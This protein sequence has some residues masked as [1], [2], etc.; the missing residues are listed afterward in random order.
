MSFCEWRNQ[1]IT[2]SCSLKDIHSFAQ[3]PVLIHISII[4]LPLTEENDN[5]VMNIFF[6]ISANS[7]GH[8]DKYTNCKYL[9]KMLSC[10]HELLKK[11]CKATCLCEGKIH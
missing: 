5:E 6:F 7:C 2:Q 3:S 1:T 10:E 4:L 11:G 8:E 9:K